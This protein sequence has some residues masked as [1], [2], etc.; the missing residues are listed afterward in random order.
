MKISKN[1]LKFIRSLNQKKQRDQNNVFLAEG[2]KNVRVCDP[3]NLAE[4]QKVLKEEL[5]S[6]G[7]SVIISRRPC[8]LLKY[9]KHKPS[10]TVDTEKCIGCTACARACQYI[11][12]G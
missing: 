6:D 7:P 1:K 12:L 8:A 11:F 3:Y 9:V 10:L 2:I 4:V 5:E